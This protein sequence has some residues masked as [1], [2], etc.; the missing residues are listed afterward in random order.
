M[1]IVRRTIHLHSE[2]LGVW[3]SQSPT[4]SAQREPSCSLCMLMWSPSLAGHSKALLSA[5][6]P[7]AGRT[8]VSFSA[9]SRFGSRGILVLATRLRG[10]QV[11][12]RKPGQR[13]HATSEERTMHRTRSAGRRAKSA[14]RGLTLRSSGAPTAGHQRPAGGTRYI[15]AIRALASCRCRPLNSNVRRRIQTTVVRVQ[16]DS[17]LRCRLLV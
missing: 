2:P 9:P 1:Q 11:A 7:L 4:A 14:R 12:Q 6:V 16:P 17:V 5:V 10:I 13:A 3:V 8:K 15:F